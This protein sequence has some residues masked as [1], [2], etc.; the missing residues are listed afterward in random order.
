MMYQAI[1]LRALRTDLDNISPSSLLGLAHLEVH[2]IAPSLLVLSQTLPLFKSLQTLS[3]QCNSLHPSEDFPAL[4]LDGLTN[5]SIVYLA[6]LRVSSIRL[7]ERCKLTI[8]TT[9]KPTRYE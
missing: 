9:G 1:A 8:F 7:S 3:L 5:L 6:H 2:N 4:H